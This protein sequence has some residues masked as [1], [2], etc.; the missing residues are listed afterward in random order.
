[1]SGFNRNI[2]NI[3]FLVISAIIILGSPYRYIRIFYPEM[4]YLPYFFE[5]FLWL[6]VVLR[7][8]FINGIKINKIDFIMLL[9][10]FLG[11]ISFAVLSLRYGLRSQQVFFATYALPLSV[12][13]YVKGTP[14]IN[15]HILDR[16]I[17]VFTI[18]G[19]LLLI[20]EFYSV[21]YLNLNIFS[22]A[23]YWESGGVEG[24]HASKTNYAFL[25][26]LTRP[27]GM[28]A[29]PQSTGSVFAAL[30]IYFFSKHVLSE[31]GF[32]S[33]TDLVYLILSLLA[34]YISGSRTAFVIFILILIFIFRK[35]IAQVAISFIFG[36][37]VL[38]VFV[39]TTQVSLKGYSNVI[40]KFFDGLTI[41][42]TDRFFDLFFG[43]GLNS[44]VGR[45]I[46]G[47]DEV[48]L[49]NHLFY[50][51]LFM[52]LILA[53]LTFLLFKIYTMRL[54]KM[55]KLNIPPEHRAYYMAYLLFIFTLILGALHY[56]PLMRYPSNVLVL[57]LI[58][59][60]SRDILIV[61][62]K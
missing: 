25:G 40:P 35:R 20:V 15:V 27:W 51:G 60:V 7:L 29:M 18:F 45:I 2:L 30:G 50:G 56:D 17:K 14:F 4:N 62:G 11:C 47:V 36:I 46:I 57:T 39:F 43:Q 19:L 3:P 34:V 32:R 26:E 24:F 23:A 5:L 9:C 38:S 31:Y 53:F 28:M 58:A 6:I 49:L 16:L 10:L 52:Y 54:S 12:Y 22:F 1:M 42:S 48:H 61:K 13:F 59:L 55:V 8:F 37:L 44:V 21:N 41:D 33:K